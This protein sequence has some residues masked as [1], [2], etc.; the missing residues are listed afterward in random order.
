MY[1]CKECLA[2][3][4]EATTKTIRLT[5]N[6]RDAVDIVCCPHCGGSF[7]EAELCAVCGYEGD[8]VEDGLC[9]ECFDDFIASKKNDWQ[10]CI[11]AASDEK[12]AVKINGFLAEMFSP[13]EIEEILSRELFLASVIKPI[14][15][16]PFLLSDES[17]L[18]D[19]IKEGV[20]K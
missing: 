2:T 8:E 6:P 10:W 4:D 15:C 3:F 18:A 13:A 11:A 12:N 17:W 19:K 7:D 16:E 1:K 14:D 5:D 20:N 9:L